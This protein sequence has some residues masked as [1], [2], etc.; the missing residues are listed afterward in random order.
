M[1]RLLTRTARGERQW[2]E[3]GVPSQARRDPLFGI[4]GICAVGAGGSIERATKKHMATAARYES[5][6]E[7]AATTGFAVF[8]QDDRLLELN[9]AL[10]ETAVVD[11]NQLVG[12]PLA[13]IIKLMLPDLVQFDGE[14][15]KKTKAFVTRIAERWALADGRPVEVETRG[16]RWKF[17]TC[18]PRPGGG[19]AYISADITPFKTDQLTLRENEELFRCLS[20]THPLPIWM[21]DAR[22]GEIL[23][24]SH[25]G[26]KLIGRDWDPDTPQFITEHYVRKSDRREV[27]R[28]LK[29]N[30]GLI[31][32]HE[33]QLKKADGTEFWISATMRINTFEGRDVVIAGV[34]DLSERKAREEDLKDARETLSD[35]IESLS[36]GFAL[37]DSD[38]R[39]VMCNSRY[40]EFHARCADVIETGVE[41]SKVIGTA[42]DRG[43][44]PEALGREEEWL[45]EHTDERNQFGV[46]HEYELDGDRWMK[47]VTTSTRDGGFV[48][49][50]ADISDR[51]RLAR[52]Q[53]ERTEQL[54]FLI[55]HHPMPVWMNDAR[56]GQII[57]ESRVTR[58]LF[59]RDV[60]DD[61]PV[62][63]R[64]YF[65][66]DEDYL[67]A[68]RV[69]HAEGVLN[70]WEL[71]LKKADGT[72]VWV[73]CNAKLTEFDGRPV[74]LAGIVDVTQRREREQHF[75]F[76]IENHPSPVALSDAETGQIIYESPAGAELFGREWTPDRP[77]QAYTVYARPE[78]RDDMVRQ[79]R[80]EGEVKDFQTQLKRN[81]ATSFWA[82]INARMA[83]FEGRSVI[84]VNISD[85]SERIEREQE[86]A[87]AREVMN[88]AIES[89]AEGFA[90]YDADDGLVMCNTRY[91]EMHPACA[92][93]L[94]PGIKW[95]DFLRIGAE[96]G[97]FPRAIG[98][99]DA[100][101]EERAQDR[102][103]YRQNHEFQHAD[104]RWYS[105]SNCPTRH[106]GAVVTRV[107]IT[108]RKRMEEEERERDA[109]VR[110]VLNACPVPIQ[111]TRLDGTVL[112]RSPA[113]AK[114]FG[115]PPSSKSY[116]ADAGT[117]EPYLKTLIERGTVEDFE[118]RFVRADGTV[119]WGSVSSKLIDFQGEPVIVSN[120][121]DLTDRKAVDA[122][123]AHQKE[124]LHQSEKLSALGE[125]L[126]GVAHELNNPLSI[127]V[128]QAL[129]LKE[130]AADETTADRA[131]KIG[132]AADRCSRIV[133]TFLSMA[134]Q[135][136]SELKRID[137]NDVLESSMEVAGYG[138]RS[139]DIH[140]K[141]KFMGQLPR[142]YADA[143]QL[144][145]V[146]INL[147][148]NAQQA[149]EEIDGER[150][151]TLS[152]DYD[153]VTN[154]IVVK[155]TDNG[156]GVPEDI[157]SRIFEPFFTTKEVGSGT[158]IGLAF[159]HRIVERHDGKISV[160]SDTGVGTTFTVRLPAD[161][162][163]GEDA[164][165]EGALASTAPGLSILVVDDE[166][167]VA[168]LISEI[169]SIDGHTVSKASSGFAALRILNTNRFDII[170]S[171][172]KMPNLDGQGL[173]DE[174]RG[175]A[176]DLIGRLAF[177]TG[178]TIS[179]KAREFLRASGRPYIE[180]PIRPQD[181]RE[182]VHGLTE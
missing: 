119:F 111:M 153:S 109:L 5:S 105:V 15:V 23:Y 46:A 148:V 59:N 114:L 113:T 134:R 35:A 77:L 65:Q 9:T 173:F 12:E 124:A 61:T 169:L 146:F 13:V 170:L 135:Q 142:I 29:E 97:Q 33:V 79:L 27:L 162:A 112:Y 176:P 49:S 73:I 180:K 31:E 24:E 106:G 90:L 159:C 181:L 42:I 174:L 30:D 138:L 129:L 62:F 71:P 57:Y 38:E 64:D 21:N 69:L 43:Q 168:E 140:V 156:R 20:Q 171:D 95:L 103:H 48:V 92:E 47:A 6:N 118:T 63:A 2:D 136:P 82:S 70:D 58:E 128:G 143:D 39:L 127:V 81:D 87:H 34:L 56:D 177:V 75:K 104:G 14:P 78:E 28:L 45:A 94:V 80:A 121:A 133:K 151:L 32:D 137:I 36:E 167:D 179:P 93:H 85:Q 165:A 178:D 3:S 17:F 131:A 84:L 18:H 141:L 41:W 50:R 96:R 11:P 150:R 66:R 102:L 157:R 147:V 10:F 54:R 67:E 152:T 55:E 123:L 149:L 144:N 164:V 139:S 108:E 145:Q 51:K 74:I 125:L 120:T 117:R 89:L 100:W 98:R 60:D 25:S 161:R 52:Q 22:T 99:I 7:N 4:N 155:V 130:T 88:D 86:L 101:L 154:E 116:Y 175:S 83:E 8:D 107:D 44:Y 19:I 68:G 72:P 37:Y 76:L 110:Q 172:L 132:N 26:S 160:I 91:K 126:A 166:D 1:R 16:G 40:R 163:T 182:L 122:E 115:E 53:A 158:G